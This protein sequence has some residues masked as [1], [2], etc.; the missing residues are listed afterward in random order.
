MCGNQEWQHSSLTGLG[1]GTQGLSRVLVHE[2]W[3]FALLPWLRITLD[4]S[5][6]EHGLGSSSLE[7]NP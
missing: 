7:L 3:L 2:V 5:G 1:V 6:K 4:K